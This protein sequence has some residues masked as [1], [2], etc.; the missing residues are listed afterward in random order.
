M[1]IAKFLKEYDLSF[2]TVFKASQFLG[3]KEP[4]INAK[5]TPEEIDMFLKAVNDEEFNNRIN[6]FQGAPRV[7]R[8]TSRRDFLLFEGREDLPEW[9]EEMYDSEDDVDVIDYESVIM[10]SFENGTS[11]NYG[12]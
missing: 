1:R 12:L 5:L 2:E 7:K 3:V 4:T 11:E 8:P 9:F 6:E 10:R